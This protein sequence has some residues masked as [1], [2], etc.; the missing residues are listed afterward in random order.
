M[1][2]SAAIKDK[3]WVILVVDDEE[4]MLTLMQIKLKAEGFD[5]EISP[6]AENILDIVWQHPPDVILLDIS[7]AGVDGGTVCRLLK[8][9]KSTV[10]IPILMVSGNPNIGSVART[11]GA[12]G[13]IAK[14]FDIKEVKEKICEALE[15]NVAR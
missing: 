3:K 1:N 10:N 15:G 6:N 2:P 7:I 13:Y 9:N 5:V 11:C 14:P 8:T 4:D 12:D